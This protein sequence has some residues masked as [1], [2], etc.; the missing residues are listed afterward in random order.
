MPTLLTR[1]SSRPQRTTVSWTMRGAVG[2]PGDVGQHGLAGAAFGFD[3]CACAL[4]PF[5]HLI[6][7][8][9][10]R[11]MTS[12]QDGGCAPVADA[13]GARTGAGN[14]RHLAG[15]PLVGAWCCCHVLTPLSVG[16][17]GSIL[18]A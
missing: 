6:D 15:K 5:L 18:A 16:A 7:Q 13:V 10:A 9:D 17:R 3:H 14:D 1:M 12:E 8:R 2:G 11:A 4:D